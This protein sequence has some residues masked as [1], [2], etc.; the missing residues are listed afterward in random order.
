MKIGY[1]RAVSFEKKGRISMPS[2]QNRT[3]AP[4]GGEG[5]GFSGVGGERWGTG[6]GEGEKGMGYRIEP[7][8][9]RRALWK[10]L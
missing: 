4:V 9:T 3:P 5:G 8:R 2:C 10:A 6:V 1:P 7:S